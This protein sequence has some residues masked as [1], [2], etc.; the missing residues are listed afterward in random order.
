M[1]KYIPVATTYSSDKECQL[2]IT[3]Y[4]N[5]PTSIKTHQYIISKKKQKKEKKKLFRINNAHG[6][7]LIHSL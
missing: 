5:S 2:L 4:H 6:K 7:Y 3:S 1:I